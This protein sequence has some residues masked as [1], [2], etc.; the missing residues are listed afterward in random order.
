MLFPGDT[1][2]NL[3]K[4]GEDMKTLL[5]FKSSSLDTAPH[6]SIEMW[7]DTSKNNQ[8]SLLLT[9]P[10]F[11]SIVSETLCFLTRLFSPESWDALEHMFDGTVTTHVTE[12]EQ[13]YTSRRYNTLIKLVKLRRYPSEGPVFHQPFILGLNIADR[14]KIAHLPK[15]NGDHIH[16]VVKNIGKALG[17]DCLN[18]KGSPLMPYKKDVIYLLRVMA[19]L[20]VVD[21]AARSLDNGFQ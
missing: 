8:L 6:Y 20:A 21:F 14:A 16:Q 3:E 9:S 5:A 4:L 11:C 18:F 2:D 19:N 7:F 12:V 1:H 15:S 13:P 10:Q 17:V